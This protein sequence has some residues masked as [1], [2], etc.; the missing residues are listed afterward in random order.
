LYTFG[1]SIHGGLGRDVIQAAVLPIPTLVPGLED[2]TTVTCSYNHTL[3]VSSKKL[4]A[5]GSNKYGQ[6]GL[7]YVADKVLIPTLVSDLE[8]VNMIATDYKHTAVISKGKLYTF[9]ENNYGQLGLGYK[10]VQ[11]V[12]VPTLVPG[13]E[14]VTSV[15]CGFFHTLVISGGRIYVFGDN[16]YGQLGLSNGSD[17]PILEPTVVP[18]FEDVTSVACGAHHS[19]IVSKGRLYTFG[20]N[21]DGQL[22]LAGVD[23]GKLVLPTLIPDLEGVTSVTCGDHHT[24]VIIN[25]E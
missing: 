18:G 17:I 5:F 16:N 23:D 8:D 24:A 12:L 19:A 3:V 21:F 11:P 1:A 22:G 15:A 14:N 20:R 13:L 2:V 25:P 10:S 7:G 6:L 4:Y 9:G